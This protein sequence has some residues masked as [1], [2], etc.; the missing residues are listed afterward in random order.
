LGKY[1]HK[2]ATSVFQEISGTTG[3][4]KNKANDFGAIVGSRQNYANQNA[5]DN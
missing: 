5:I 2:K 4:Q 3:I 1:F